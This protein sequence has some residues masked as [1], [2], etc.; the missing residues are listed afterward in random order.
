M[1][2]LLYSLFAAKLIKTWIP[3]KHYFC[4]FAVL[5]II[6]KS[7]PPHYEIL[8]F[9]FSTPNTQLNKVSI[10]RFAKNWALPLSMIAGVVVY[11]IGV[12]LNLPV[13]AKQVCMSAVSVIQPVLIFLMLFITFCKVNTSEISMHAWHFKGI[14]FQVSLFCL[15]AWLST[16]VDYSWRVIIEGAMLCFICPT[17]TAAAVVTQKL[18]G[19]AGQITIYTILI[20]ITAAVTV[21]VVFPLTHPQ[22]GMNFLVDFGLINAKV[23]PL[24]LMPVVA[25]AIVRR[26]MPSIPETLRRHP[27]VAFYIWCFALTL[28]IAVTVRSIANSNVSLF[29]EAGIAA[30]AAVACIAQFLFGRYIGRNYG[31]DTSITAGQSLGQK[32]TVVAIWMGYTFLDPIT[33]IAGGFYSVWHNLFNSWQLYQMRKK[34]A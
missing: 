4:N 25:A 24:L 7:T 19:S 30:A 2:F 31:H 21:A 5:I 33:S 27:N 34:S 20:N 26:W 22:D 3:T 18:G 13:E 12:A 11:Y 9:H 10:L 16:K 23:M 32:N 14:V 29:C 1:F 8:I 15:L 17:A 6:I 28:A